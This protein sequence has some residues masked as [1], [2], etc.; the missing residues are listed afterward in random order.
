MSA[1]WTVAPTGD[2]LLRDGVETFLL[3]D[4]IW[5]AFTTPTRAEWDD[6]V[7]LRGEQGFNALLI[8]V[9]PIV[10]DRSEG[11][12]TPYAPRDDGTWDF[13]RLQPEYFEE[14]RWALARARDHGL[15]PALVVMWNNYAPGTWGAAMSPWTVM[16]DAQTERYVDAMLD[17]FAEFE[18]IYIVSGD[19]KFDG[20]AGIARWAAVSDRIRAH[21]PHALQTMH[22]API[23]RIPDE[24]ARR[25]DVHSYQSG[26]D[27]EWEQWPID[28][29]EFH[30][31]L[32]PRKPIMNLEPPYEG[33]GRGSGAARHRAADVR[34]G[35]WRGIVA[36]A[37]AGVGYGA[38]GVWSW[39]ERGA[40]FNGAW[41]S[42][43]PYPREVALRFDGARDAAF[44]RELVE[45]HRLYALEHRPELLRDDRSGATAGASPDGGTV[46]VFAPHPFEF[47]IGIDPDGFEVT[48]Y[49]LE[50]R[51][52]V[53]VDA[54]AADGALRVPL[55]D[56]LA[57]LLIVATRRA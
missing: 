45:R 44:A 53:G 25:I 35:T 14:A 4:T 51:E 19:D 52:A 47:T 3:A 26:H 39:H 42:S 55:P 23:A 48:V 17:A 18:P 12:R 9:L 43:M 8:S 16:S 36:G 2:R 40:P 37:T 30:L 7:A 57:D 31:G 10:N 6:Y 29:A 24:L 33:H 32:A 54:I 56:R 34:L 15:T 5:A 22:S 27:G 46:A 28:L 1:I 49:D 21:S 41:F 20:E 13:E 50:R 11:A 38:H